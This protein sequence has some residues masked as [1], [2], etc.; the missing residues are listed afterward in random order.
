MRAAID[1]CELKRALAQ[2]VEETEDTFGLLC[3]GTFRFRTVKQAKLLAVHLGS[4]AG[5]PQMAVG[6]LEVLVNAVEH[7]NLEIGYEMKGELLARGEL[8][9]EIARRLAA[10]EYRDRRVEVRT[11][12]HSDRLEITIED[13]GPGFDFERYQTLDLD[14]LFDSH[15]RGILLADAALDIRYVE[16]GNKVVI[17]LP[18]ARAKK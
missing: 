15:G 14:R 6:L 8:E 10:P 13:A 18:L 16:P 7:G 9:A 17:G 4:A 12:R 5:D 3:E 11:T 2:R 1:T